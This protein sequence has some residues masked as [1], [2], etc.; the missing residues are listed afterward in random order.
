MPAAVVVL[1][2][3]VLTGVAVVDTARAG[4]PRPLVALAFAAMIGFGELFRINLPGDRRSS[5]VGVAGGLAYVLVLEV[6]PRPVGHDV[7]DVVAVTALASLAGTLVHLLAG[8]SAHLLDLARR[9]LALWVAAAAFRPWQGMLIAQHGSG[10]GPVLVLAALGAVAAG[11]AVDVGISSVL[12]ARRDGAPYAATVRNELVSAAPL[13]LSMAATGMLIALAAPLMGLWALPVFS[14]PL[15]VTQYSFR[16]YAA[17][18]ATYRQTI[19]SLSRV[20]ELG[21]YVVPGHSRRVSALALAV[22]KEFGLPEDDLLD[23]EYAALMHDI[24]QLSLAEPIPGGST[25][26]VTSAERSRIAALGAQI[27]RTTG[28][29]PAVADIL[30]RQAD[31]YRRNL[32]PPDAT[33]PLAC[34]VIK[35]ASAYDDVAAGSVG[36]GPAIAMERLRRGMAYEYDP[37]VVEA[38]ARVVERG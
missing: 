7:L 5:P 24:G 38:L 18:R 36:G 6:G 35:A 2:S 23:L 37:Q 17:I 22:G 12:R 19:G 21:G 34:R 33:L 31:P 28:T 3:T 16:R 8:R 26:A 20:T 29:M 32:E 9:V 11:A 1:A 25:L 14:V 30:E 13:G 27:V 4:V 15:L 10:A